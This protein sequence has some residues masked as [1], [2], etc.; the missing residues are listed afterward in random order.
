MPN[1]REGRTLSRGE[2]ARRRAM[3]AAIDAVAQLGDRVR[4]VDIAARAQM[5]TG[6]ILYYFGRKEGL[7]LEALRWSEND[8][9]MRM[10]SELASQRGVRR[11]LA[12]W[13]DFYLPAGTGDPRWT[14]WAQVLAKPPQAESD[15][16]ALDSFDR[17]WEEE[18]SSIVAAG[19]RSGTFA[20]V[21]ADAFAVRARTTLDGLSLEVLMGSLRMCRGEAA[22]LAVSWLSDDLGVARKTSGRR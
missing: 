18:L 7:L 5:S 21:D 2:A 17:A 10:R 19:V 6:H 14:L 8:L 1:Q 13:V 22:E 9:I 4:M 20:A 3:E 12:G 11:K 15:R 16:R